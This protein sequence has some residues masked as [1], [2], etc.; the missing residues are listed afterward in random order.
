MNFRTESFDLPQKEQRRC[1]SLD[2]KPRRDLKVEGFRKGGPRFP[3]RQVSRPLECGTK[4]FRGVKT[5]SIR[6]Y[7]LAS[8]ALMNRSRSMSRSMVSIGCPVWS[9]YRAFILDRR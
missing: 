7:A 5:A 6:P 3:D 4:S 2:M 9:E 8:S 1:L